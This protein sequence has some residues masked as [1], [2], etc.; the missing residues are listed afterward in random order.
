MPGEVILWYKGGGETHTYIKLSP[1]A[2]RG[3]IHLLQCYFTHL[4]M[5][6]KTAAILTGIALVAFLSFQSQGAEAHGKY[7]QVLF[8][9]E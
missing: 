8:N 1:A 2:V 5:G 9:P 3:H 6:W 7:Q 4:N